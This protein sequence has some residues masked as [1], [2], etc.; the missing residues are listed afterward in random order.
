MKRAALIAVLLAAVAAAPGAPAKTEQRPLAW[1]SKTVVVG[2]T[3]EQALANA[4]RGRGATIVGQVG[5][6]RAVEVLA[7]GDPAAL[8]AALSRAPG[9]DYVQAPAVRRAQMEPALAPANVPG[10]AYQWQFAVTGADRVPEPVRRGARG[11]RIAVID[12]GADLT[13][14]DIEAKRPLTYNAIDNGRDVTDTV[15]HGT[16]VSSI[17]AGSSSNGDGIAGM[18]GEARLIAIKASSHGFFTDFETA[19]AIAYAVDAGA[20]VVNLSLGGEGYSATELRA[21]EYAVARDVL[22]VAAAGNEYLRGNKTSYPAA[23]LQPVGSNG[24]GGLGLSVGASTITGARAPFSNTGSYISLAAPGHNV[25]GAVSRES[26]PKQY[27]R[28]G[29]PG[30]TKGLY[31]YSS[32]TSFAAPQVAGAAALVWGANSSLTTA[33][34]TDIL[35]KTASGQSQW[36]PELGFGVINVAAAVEV[37]QLTP[38]V[39]LSAYKYNDTARLSWRGSTRRERG[40][41]V[42]ALDGKGGSTVVYQGLGFSTQV[43]GKSGVTNAFM[44]QS[45][46]AGGA[47]IAESARIYVTFGQAQSVLV[48]RGFRFKD[49]GKRY[50]IAVFMLAAHAPDVKL[51]RRMV[52]LEEKL[53]GSWKLASYQYTDGAGRVLWIVP[54]GR[55]TIR[56]RFTGTADLKAALS[57]AITVVG[58]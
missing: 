26:S 31:G 15:G 4:L 55:H 40:Y 57:R 3:T 16:F 5:A 44:V 54:R 50:S 52:R 25:F 43:N 46:D 19:A 37:A 39:S 38:A 13:A 42:L 47:V 53:G 8:A 18:G 36:N 58:A 45:L 17:A 28:V 1:P 6:L 29:L 32:G 2:Y 21:I 48:G 35:K 27:P 10:G 11:V 7:K 23:L 9:I 22:L 30:A 20:K 34:V 51:G 14:P 24:Q 41:R 12:S 56:A 33:Q 49:R